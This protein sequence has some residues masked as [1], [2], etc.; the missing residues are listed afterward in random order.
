M[1]LKRK[2]LI[3]L[4]LLILLWSFAGYMPGDKTIVSNYDKNV[5]YPYQ[6]F[7]GCL[8]GTIPF[9]IGDVLYVLAGAGILVIVV[10]W[11]ISLFKFGQNLGELTAAGLRL[12]NTVLAVYLLFLISWGANYYKPPL[13]EL[14]ELNGHTR[15]TLKLKSDSSSIDAEWVSDTPSVKFFRERDSAAIISF[16]K[17]L[18]DKLNKFAPYYKPL[19]F[20]EI[21]ERSKAYYREYTDSKVKRYGLEIKPTLFGYF[22]KQMAVEGYYNPFTGEGQIDAKLPAFIMPFLVCHEMAHQAGIAAE[23]DANLLA[24]TLCTTAKDSSFNY[25]AYLNIWLYTNNRLRRRD[26][27]MANRFEARLNKLTKAHIDTLEQISKKYENEMAR[28]SSEIYDG[29]LKM[30]DQKEGIRSYSNVAVSAWLVELKRKK[31]AGG[32]IIIP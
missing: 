4:L 2:I 26:S 27:A 18:V 17:F 16:D 15:L 29:Y 8:L 1:N 7:R 19:S 21:N 24:Y 23:G 25:A 13:S 9:S 3:L 10:R 28:C 32:I 6:T 11:L 20:S 5:F 30:Q 14:W 12:V 31:G 22:L